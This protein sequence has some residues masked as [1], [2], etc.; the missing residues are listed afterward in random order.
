MR[1]SELLC[2]YSNKGPERGGIVTKLGLVELKNVCEDPI[3]GFELS[4]EDLDKLDEINTLATF[5]THPGSSSNLSHEDY[6][7]FMSYPRLTHYIIGEDGISTY[8][9]LNGMLI[10]ES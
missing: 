5:H 2:F 10:N 6:E 8:K 9:V 4:Y 7:S 1:E 3:N